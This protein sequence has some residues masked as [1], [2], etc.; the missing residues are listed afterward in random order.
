[1]LLAAQTKGLTLAWDASA[2]GDQVTN[3][4][5]YQATGTNT[6]FQSVADV[7]TNL[8]YT[9][10]ISP[11]IYQFRVTALNFWGVESVPSNTISTPPVP[12]Q[13]KQPILYVIVGGKTNT[14]VNLGP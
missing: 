12:G 2:S 9:V 7:G 1:M 10:A 5:V 6:T 14:I 13:V 3:Y 11:G 4:R 8:L